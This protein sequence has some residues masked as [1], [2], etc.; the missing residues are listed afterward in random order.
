M[1]DIERRIRASLP[2]SVRRTLAHG[3]DHYC[4]IC[5][6][7][8]KEFRPFVTMKQAWCPVCG[9]MPWHR[10]AHL[11]F[12]KRTNLF[13]ATPKRMLHIAPELEFAKRF[14]SMPQLDYVAADLDTSRPMVTEKMDI[15]D[16][17]HPDQTFD[18]IYCSHV[19]EHVP[20]DRKAM[21]EFQR[22]LKLGGWAV[23][24][25]PMF[26]EPTDEDPAITDPAERERRFGQ[27]DHVRRYGPD[28]ADRLQESGFRVER[29]A[30]AEMA[31]GEQ[32]AKRMVAWGP[33]FY[34]TRA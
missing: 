5:E 26:E 13:D 7:T 12:Q 15:C 17:R 22:V 30:G 25:V 23:L 1:G 11:V 18:V 14:R 32:E 8:V 6:S 27:V 31:G 21:R 19:L 16:I 24:I 33:A 28:F 10:L 34:C 29:L 20:D 4:P 2:L 3:D 9:S